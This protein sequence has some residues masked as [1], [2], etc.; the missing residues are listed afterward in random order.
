MLPTAV[1]ATSVRNSGARTADT[2]WCNTTIR[3]SRFVRPRNPL[4][5]AVSKGRLSAHHWVRF[6]SQKRITGHIALIGRAPAS[7][8]VSTQREAAGSSP[9]VSAVA[10]ACAVTRTHHPCEVVCKRKN[11]GVPPLRPSFIDFSALFCGPMAY[12]KPKQVYTATSRRPMFSTQNG[13]GVPGRE[14]GHSKSTVSRVRLPSHPLRW[15]NGVSSLPHRVREIHSWQ[16][17]SPSR[18]TPSRT[19]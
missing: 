12:D 8:T 19:A 11:L 3:Q 5:F 10:V 9:A 14:T 2:S 18:S 17:F 7:T 13:Q 6:P 1:L 4:T 16:F 15:H